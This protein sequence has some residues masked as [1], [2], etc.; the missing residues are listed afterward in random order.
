MRLREFHALKVWYGQH[1]RH[2]VER[3]VWDVVLTIWMLGWIGAP[4][5]FI[6]HTGWGEGACLVVLFLP[7]TYVALRRRLH[8]AQRLRCDWINALR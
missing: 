1:G 6:V 3:N 4:I 7:E 2:P 5:A 8:R